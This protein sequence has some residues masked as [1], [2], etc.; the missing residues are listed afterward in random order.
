MFAIRYIDPTSGQIIH[1]DKN[2]VITGNDPAPYVIG[3]EIKALPKTHYKAGEALTMDGLKINVIWNTG[4]KYETAFG[5][6]EYITCS[7]TP[8][9]IYD[10]I[11][12]TKVT[13]TH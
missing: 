9:A 7:P 6:S 8:G 11:T 1:S 3:I 12:M 13:V 2:P 5:P 4:V 10:P